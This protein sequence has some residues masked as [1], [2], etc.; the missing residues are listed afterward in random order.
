MNL[1]VCF[2][3]GLAFTP[4]KG[5]EKCPECGTS[6]KEIMKVDRKAK[7]AAVKWWKEH[8]EALREGEIV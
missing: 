6:R 7:R 8:P 3:C 4:K 2:H 5:W 1:K